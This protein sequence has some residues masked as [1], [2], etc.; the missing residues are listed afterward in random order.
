MCTLDKKIPS[1]ATLR[2][3]AA[4]ELVMTF[5][6]ENQF[7]SGISIALGTLLVSEAH[8]VEKYFK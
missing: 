5:A 2:V 8:A 1:K 3:A 7:G 4:T 6:F